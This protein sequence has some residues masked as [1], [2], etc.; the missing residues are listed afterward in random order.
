MQQTIDCEGTIRTLLV[1]N[2]ALRPLAERETAMI[3]IEFI[4]KKHE[5]LGREAFESSEEVA[6]RLAR[7]REMTEQIVG[8]DHKRTVENMPWRSSGEV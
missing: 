6:R 5:L 1:L 7:L 8:M 2:N 4:R 3:D